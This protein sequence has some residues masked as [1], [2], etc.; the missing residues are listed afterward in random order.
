MIRRWLDVLFEWAAWLGAALFLIPVMVGVVAL[1]VDRSELVTAKIWTNRPALLKDSALANSWSNGAP[2]GDADALLTELMGS[3]WFANEVLK[4]ADSGFVNLSSNEQAQLRLGLRQNLKHQADGLNLLSISYRTDRPQAGRS[5]MSSVIVSLGNAGESDQSLQ[6]GAVVQVLHDQVAAAGAARQRAL[7]AVNAYAARKSQAELLWDP[8][9][10]TLVV[11]ATTATDYYVSVE[12]QAKQAQLQ[13][14]AV[15][16]IRQATFRVV[17]APSIS[18]KQ[19]DLR[20]PAVK[21]YLEA[22]AGTAG[23]EI[24]LVYVIG[25]RDPRVRSGDDVKKLLGIAYLGS[26]PA[27]PS[28]A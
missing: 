26:T 22:L 21:Y 17:D 24:L 18:P 23:V 11:D 25:L 8:V 13:Q 12:N 14:L 27:L 5:I 28:T 7:D 9:Y 19:F 3:D 2:A 1:V 20:T 15:P 16:A 10:Q 4:G 6:T